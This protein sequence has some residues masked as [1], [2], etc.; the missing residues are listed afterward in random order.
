[1]QPSQPSPCIL[2]LM[3][4]GNLQST[5]GKKEIELQVCRICAPYP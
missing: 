1:M 4:V 3:L 2:V 5:A